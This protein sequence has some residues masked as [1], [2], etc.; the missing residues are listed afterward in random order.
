M[1]S[2]AW[3]MITFLPV[4]HFV[5]IARLLD[6]KRLNSQR[7]EALFILRCVRNAG[8]RYKRFQNAGYCRMWLGHPEALA[9]YY[10]TMCEEWTGRGFSMGVSTFEA[11]VMGCSQFDV[12]LPGWLGDDRLHA[13]HRAALLFKDPEHYGGLGWVEEPVVRY[14]WPERLA[15]SEGWALVPPKAGE[16]RTLAMRRAQLRARGGEH[17]RRP[18][19]RR[20]VKRTSP[21]LTQAFSH[22][23]SAPV[24]AIEL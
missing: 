10:N 9:V 22:L 21:T 18:P 11:A 1:R 3:P 19:E 14:L 24:Y 4:P 15:D 23:R 2:V 13:T 16:S 8:G 17:R 20:T 5:Q 7:V 6:N 12:A